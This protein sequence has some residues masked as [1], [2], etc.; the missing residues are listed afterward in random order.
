MYVPIVIFPTKKRQKLLEKLKS[1]FKR[2]VKW[3]K[4]RSQ[5]TIQSNNSD[6][7]YLIDLTFTKVN[8]LFGFSSE[9]IEENN[10]KKEI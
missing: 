3:N 9:R 2:T 6:V 5:M 10:A 8:R 7:N 4:Y 1:R